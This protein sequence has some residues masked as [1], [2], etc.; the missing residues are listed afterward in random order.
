MQ[1][2]QC[3][4]NLPSTE[5]LFPLDNCLSGGQPQQADQ[6]PA[7]GGDGNQDEESEVGNQEKPV[8]EEGDKEIPAEER[9]D[10]TGGRASPSRSVTSS[11]LVSEQ[12]DSEF[13]CSLDGGDHTIELR[14]EWV[15]SPLEQ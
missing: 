4:A 3:P 15:V 1:S 7:N 11:T 10:A 14:G 12:G 8:D 5:K 9:S 6:D 2:T 13:G